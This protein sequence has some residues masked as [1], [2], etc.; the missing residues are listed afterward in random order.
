MMRI[1]LSC[2]IALTPAWSGPVKVSVTL[3]RCAEEHWQ[4]VLAD[5]K[6]DAARLLSLAGEK[7]GVEAVLRAEFEVNVEED[8]P[9]IWMDGREM[10]FTAGW[11]REDDPLALKPEAKDK[12]HVGTVIRAEGEFD[13][14]KSLM[15]VDLDLRHDFAPPT[16]TTFSYPIASDIGPRRAKT[17]LKL[18]RF[19]RIEWRGA[20]SGRHSQP[21]LAASILVPAEDGTGGKA[22]RWFIIVTP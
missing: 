13:D 7:K 20:V 4:R 19:H 22:V 17:Q 3:L 12:R 9:T 18:P 8:K 21:V 14:R 2:L 1:A 11:R 16:W 5:T 6:P 15:D 10:E